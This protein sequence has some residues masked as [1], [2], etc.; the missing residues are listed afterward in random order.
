MWAG[1]APVFMKAVAQALLGGPNRKPTYRLTL[2]A[3]DTRWHW[4]HTLPQTLVVTTL[5]VVAI[6]AIRFHTYPSITLLV[7]SVYWGA[8]NVVLL[9]NFISR[10]WHGVRVTRNFL[11]RRRTEVP[12][13]SSPL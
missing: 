4:R 5:A 9:A 2:K 11:G 3:D 1:L 7:G 13:P 10:S 12:L 8:L 6:T